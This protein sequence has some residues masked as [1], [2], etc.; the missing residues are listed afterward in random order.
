[1]ASDDSRLHYRRATARRKMVSS[2]DPNTGRTLRNSGRRNLQV[3]ILRTAPDVPGRRKG[4]ESNGGNTFRLMRQP[5]RRKITSRENQTPRVLLANNDRRLR[6]IR[7]KMRKMPKACANYPT[8]R[9]SSFL[10][11]VALSL[12]ALGHGYCRTSA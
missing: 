9:R 10:H 4:E 11:H 2:Q 7:T 12:Y 8:T 3:E 6:K 5:F 1:M